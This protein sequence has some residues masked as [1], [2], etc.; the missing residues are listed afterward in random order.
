VALIAAFLLIALLKPWSFGEA[1][2]DSGR[3]GDRRAIP[4]GTELAIDG[5]PSLAA[6]PSIVD[7]N[8][9]ACLTD[10]TEQVV[11][12]ER[13]AGH[14]VRSW[15]AATD[16]TVSGPLDQRL[17][18]IPFFSTHV[19]GVGICAPRARTGSQQPAARLLDVQSIV[20]TATGPHAVDFGVP[21]PITLEL[22]G[23][24]PAILYGAP[25]ATL[26]KAS[27]G[28]PG[29]DPGASQPTEQLPLQ[30]SAS[31]RRHRAA[32]SRLA[33]WTTGAYAIAFEFPSA[34]PHV[35]HWL[36]IDLIQ[37]AGTSG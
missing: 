7:P 28:A 12:L 23:P 25:V 30:M 5:Q 3:S 16:V 14:E 20:Q 35:I 15:I 27:A 34:G 8:A 33:P 31:G 17:V 13:W 6:T 10:V 29:L 4:S 19:I 1:G 22:G 9:M 26:P 24:E 21:D 11:I 32:T 18:P 37:G 2:P 36:R